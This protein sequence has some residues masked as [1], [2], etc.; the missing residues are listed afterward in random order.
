M[1]SDQLLDAVGFINDE[2]IQDAKAYRRSKP[3]Y[4]VKLFMIAAAIVLLSTTAVAAA[5]MF[6]RPAEV[7]E[8][9]NN[10][11]LSDAFDSEKAINLNVSATSGEYTFTALAIVSG[12]SISDYIGSAMDRQPDRTFII[13]AIQN[14]DG[15]PFQEEEFDGFGDLL[16]TPLIKGLEPWRFNIV[17]MGGSGSGCV[18][19]GVMYFLMECDNVIMFADR[20]LY[21]GIC[22]GMF[23]GVETFRFDEITGEIASNP[24]FPGLSVVLELPID[25]SYADP[26]RAEQYLKQLCDQLGWDYPIAPVENGIS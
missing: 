10:H 5:W 8:Q 9:F 3:H 7:P 26:E 23:V 21:L 19:D 20:G 17:S 6:L 1:K 22:S 2:A 4:G 16:I 18:A 12:E 13:L 14:V 25:A 15:T 24:D 11:T